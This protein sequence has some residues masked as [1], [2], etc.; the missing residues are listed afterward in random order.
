M[1]TQTAL[2]DRAQTRW[3]SQTVSVALINGSGLTVNST[4]AALLAAEVATAGYARG[5]FS[6][7][8]GANATWDATNQRAILDNF[9]V[10][11]TPTAAMTYNGYLILRGSVI[12]SV[13]MLTNAETVAAGQTRTISIALEERRL[14]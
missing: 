8:S 5:T 4:S 2:I 14:E 7:T 10:D 11:F 13:I 9:S 3:R 1:L 12:E 6:V